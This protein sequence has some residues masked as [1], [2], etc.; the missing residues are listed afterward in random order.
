MNQHSRNKSH[1]KKT[2]NDQIN[3]TKS[4]IL[5][6]IKGNEFRKKSFY[7]GYIF[8]ESLS[9]QPRQTKVWIFEE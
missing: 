2:R 3:K 6:L 7:T 8:N 5:R 4:L 9:F 1:L